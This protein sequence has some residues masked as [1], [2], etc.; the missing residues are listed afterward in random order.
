MATQALIFT[1]ALALQ[2]YNERCDSAAAMMIGIFAAAIGQR[3]YAFFTL[4]SLRFHDYSFHFFASAARLRRRHF[5][6][7]LH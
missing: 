1:A 6:I 5:V 4:I 3:D 7:L 2:H